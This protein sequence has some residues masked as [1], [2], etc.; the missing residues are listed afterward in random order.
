MAGFFK[1]KGMLKSIDIHTSHYPWRKEHDFMDN[2][3]I[4]MAGVFSE[5][6][7]GEETDKEVEE[8]RYENTIFQET[9]YGSGDGI[10]KAGLYIPEDEGQRIRDKK[11]GRIRN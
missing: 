1:L 2:V 8:Q 6:A 7:I 4:I 10:K 11:K 9:E 5:P 3:A